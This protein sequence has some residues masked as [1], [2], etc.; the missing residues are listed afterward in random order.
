MFDL[1][2][3]AGSSTTLEVSGARPENFLNACARS[4]L[5]IQFAGP[6][7]DFTMHVRLGTGDRKKIESAAAKSSC[8]VRVLATGGGVRLRR[9]LVRR[10]LPALCLLLLLSLLF[11]SRLFIWEIRVSGNETVPTGKILDVLSQCGVDCGSFWPAFTSDN[12]RSQVLVKLPELAWVTV[13]VYGSRAEVIVRERVPRPEIV[14]ETGPCDI[15]SDKTGVV[16]EVQA[17]AG[18]AL[19]SRG[20]AVAEG[21]L[22]I[23]G[24]VESS[25]SPPRLVRALG[26]VTAQTYYELS[27]VIPADQQTKHYTGEVKNRW[28]LTIGGKRVNFYG[29][30]SISDS[31]CDKI[32]SVW[33]LGI[34]G[35]FELPV[36]LRRESCLFYETGVTARDENAAR[37]E[38][39]QLLHDR[40]LEE[41]GDTGEILSEAWSVSENGG[42]LNVCLRAVCSEEI[43][44][45]VPMDQA[46]KAALAEQFD[47]EG[48]STND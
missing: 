6:V 32:N 4:G 3:R 27:A 44:V 7:K 46:R 19:V 36:S 21:E 1:F 12:L 25:F 16:M 29:N 40:L 11:W 31:S 47:R 17:L 9:M 5:E 22:L 33:T 28:S 26:S 37:R 45:T 48:E 13:N 23:S 38:L 10:A 8:A 42:I 35:L 20:S 39:E 2:N 24:G 14:S 18:T 41:I 15:R 43:G 30:S 34:D